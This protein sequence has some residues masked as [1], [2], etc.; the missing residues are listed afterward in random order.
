MYGESCS[1]LSTQPS[2]N[3]SRIAETED[4]D[5]EHVGA[6]SPA[7]VMKT[8]NI[9]GSDDVHPEDKFKGRDKASKEGRS[10]SPRD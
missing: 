9:V 8:E 3:Q 6:L 5:Q 2:I 1:G 10:F 4:S 7:E